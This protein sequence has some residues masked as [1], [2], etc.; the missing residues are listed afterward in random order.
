[1]KDGSYQSFEAAALNSNV[2]AI[3]GVT[4]GK[5]ESDK[6]RKEKAD[7]AFLKERAQDQIRDAA[8]QAETLR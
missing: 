1:M 2:L 5:L 7:A 8:M 3:I 6:Q 4:L